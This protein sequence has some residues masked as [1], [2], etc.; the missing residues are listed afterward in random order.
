MAPLLGSSGEIVSNITFTMWGHW[1]GVCRFVSYTMFH[2]M[3]SGFH[4]MVSGFHNMFFGFHFMV[5]WFQIM[6][7]A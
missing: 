5:F 4:I 3:A 1:W 7:H 6:F 2:I